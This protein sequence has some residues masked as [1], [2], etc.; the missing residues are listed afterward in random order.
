MLVGTLYPLA[1]EAVSGNKISVGP[2]FFNLT[3]IPLMIPLFLAMPF[4]PFLPWK[5]GDVAGV[6]QRLKY[7]AIIT[8]V[9]AVISW[10]FYVGVLAPLGI[11][12]AVWLMVGALD[13]LMSRAGL[14]RVSW[15]QML[16]RLWGLPGSAWGVCLGHFGVGVTVF[17]I[18]IC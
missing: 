9:I 13:E 12:L 14:G 15:R 8:L 3:M 1:Y 2:P 16:N 5:R 17:G 11:A 6:M 7:T 4:G 10:A 18:V